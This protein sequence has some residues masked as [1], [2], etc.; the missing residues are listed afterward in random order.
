[1]R[2]GAL[3]A[4]AGLA[5]AAGLAHAASA[6]TYVGDWSYHDNIGGSEF[7]ELRAGDD[8]GDWLV[9]RGTRDACG[10]RGDRYSWMRQVMDNGWPNAVTWWVTHACAN[11]TTRVC[12]R[13]VHGQSGCSSYA[14]MGWSP[15]SQY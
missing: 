3:A 1:M 10:P 14:D 12:I 4:M 8:Y 6:Q 5:L 9:L 13:N 11:G 7:V 2:T 15:Y